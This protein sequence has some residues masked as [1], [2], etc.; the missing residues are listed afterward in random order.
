MKKYSLGW[1]YHE[2]KQYVLAEETY[3]VGLQNNTTYLP[4][5]SRPIMLY[6]DQKLLK[7]A[8][9]QVSKMMTI[10]EADW[11]IPFYKSCIAAMKGEEQ[12]ALKLL[13]TASDIGIEDT[14]MLERRGYFE[15][16]KHHEGFKRILVENKDD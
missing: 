4:L 9:E 11:R 15:N 7:K 3:S 14:D 2:Q 5:H 6:L 12:K 16:I 10:N 13:K 8:E 1:L